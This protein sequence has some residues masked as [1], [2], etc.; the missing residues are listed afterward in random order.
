MEKNFDFSTVGKRMPYSMPKDFLKDMQK[1]VMDEISKSSPTS[2]RPETTARKSRIYVMFRT[3]VAT[4]AAVTLFLVCY[5]TMQPR[6]VNKYADV[7][8]AF[9]NLSYEDQQYM[10]DNYNDDVFMED[11]YGTNF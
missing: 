7:E 3:A 4:A 5:N 2:K 10:I 11:S 9:D 1:N 6:P 8:R